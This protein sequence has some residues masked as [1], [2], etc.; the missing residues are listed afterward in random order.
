[1]QNGLAALQMCSGPDVEANLAAADRLLAEAAA[2]GAALAVLPE[3]FAVFD[4][5][6]YREVAQQLPALLARV[7]D[8]ARRHRL[9]IVAGTLPAAARPDGTAVPDGRV[10]TACHVLNAQ[11]DVVARYDKIHLFDVEVAD[12]TGSY[13]ESATFEPGDVPVCVDTPLGRLGLS[14]CYDLRFPELFRALVADGAGLVSVPSAFTALTGAAH[15]QVLLRARAIENQIFVIGAGQGGVH[16]PTRTTFGHSQIVDPWGRVLA[17]READGPGMLC[18]V[19]DRDE[20]VSLQ[21]RMPVQKH[22]RI[23]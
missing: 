5:G 13:R 23:R 22:R 6:R 12:A 10:R 20:Q 19:P 14:V 15:W 4:A 3:N 2:A 16:S 11:G 9:W 8:M 21:A 18:V 17:E 1:M 7:G